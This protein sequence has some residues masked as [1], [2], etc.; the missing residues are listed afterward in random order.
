VKLTARGAVPEV[1]EPDAVA[2]R[3]VTVLDTAMLTDLV[4]RA[5]AL[6][7]TVSEAA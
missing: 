7:V 2:I 1:G 3:G 6:S 5:D 4:F